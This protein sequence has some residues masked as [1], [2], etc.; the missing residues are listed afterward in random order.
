MSVA[1]ILAACVVCLGI[2]HRATL[3]YARDMQKTGVKIFLYNG[4]IHDE[5]FAAH[6][7]GI[8]REDEKKSMHLPRGYFDKQR[9]WTRA[10]YNF[11]RMLAPMM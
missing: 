10:G 9:I 5:A 2:V 7:A 3:G 6:C 8:F 11:A 1:Q 4:F